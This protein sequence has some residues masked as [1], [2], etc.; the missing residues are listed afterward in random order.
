MYAKIE[1]FVDTIY[2]V[3]ENSPKNGNKISR[4]AFSV[5]GENKILDMHSY[6]RGLTYNSAISYHPLTKVLLLS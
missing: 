1:E 5:P 3:N 4:Y 6:A 2:L